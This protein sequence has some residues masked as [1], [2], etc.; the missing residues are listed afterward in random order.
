MHFCYA[1]ISNQN[2][3]TT[4]PNNN[5]IYMLNFT[6]K[7]Y[8]YLKYIN[9]LVIKI[10]THLYASNFKIAFPLIF[11]IRLHCLRCENTSML[12][13]YVFSKYISKFFFC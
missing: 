5:Q 3:T 6:C 11:Q 1:I 10:L 13:I 2:N 4:L 8:E 7:E 9:V 12:L